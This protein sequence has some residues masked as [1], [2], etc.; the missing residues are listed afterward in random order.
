MPAVLETEHLTKRYWDF[1]LD[2]V[3]LA[4]EPGG[5][6]GIIGPS[7]AGKTTLI[8]SILHLVPP[9]G[10]EVRVFGLPF[11]EHEREIK[12]RIGFVNDEPLFPRGMTV[13]KIGRFVARFFERW[14]GSRFAS[15]LAEFGI[16]R[17]KKVKELSRGRRTLLSVAVA[18]SHEADLFLLDEPTAGLD[19]VIRRRVLALLRALAEE[20]EKTVI[21]ASHNTEGLT[22]IADDIVF[23][24]GGRIVLHQDKEDLLERWKWIHFRAGA[25]ARDVRARLA[26]CEEQPF[27]SK[28]LTDD[29]PALRESLAEPIAAGEVRV[30]NA[31]LGDILISMIEGA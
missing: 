8:R 10:G 27:G 7:G 9:D 14:N 15:L 20:E 1:T 22:E 5:I 31:D 2:D 25:L 11:S 6:T 21:L 29:Y 18:L 17:R 24:D 28:G 19:L 23:V 12:N 13:E 16:E 3:S 4:I 26:R 30:E